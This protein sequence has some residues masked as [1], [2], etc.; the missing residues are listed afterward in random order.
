M[1]V[2]NTHTNTGIEK[3][4]IPLRRKKSVKTRKSKIETD[5]ENKEKNYLKKENNY[6][7]EM[8]SNLTKEIKQKEIFISE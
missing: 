1:P 4:D 2:K 5:V 7:N 6:L 8:V 3:N